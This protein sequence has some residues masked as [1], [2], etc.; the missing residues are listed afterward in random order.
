VT[1]AA[2]MSIVLLAISLA[3]LMSI[4]GLQRW[5]SKHDR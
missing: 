4:S 3:V 2:A 5:R 1:G